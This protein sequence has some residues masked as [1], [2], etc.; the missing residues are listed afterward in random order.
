[1]HAKQAAEHAAHELTF[2]AG[3]VNAHFNEK[4][5]AGMFGCT[6][7]ST[8]TFQYLVNLFI[9]DVKRIDIHP[10]VGNNLQ[11]DYTIDFNDGSLIQIKSGSWA[12]NGH[13]LQTQDCRC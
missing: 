9:T 5:A 12:A 4:R 8:C 3:R 6:T 13:Y 2:M 1:M 11:S 7:S 10:D